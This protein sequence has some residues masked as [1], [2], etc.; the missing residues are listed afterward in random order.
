[1]DENSLILEIENNVKFLN[2]FELSRTYGDFGDWEQRF[3][4]ETA[5]ILNSDLTIKIRNLRNFR[6]LQIFVS[7]RP[8]VTL[9]NIYHSSKLYYSFKHFLNYFLGT[10]RGGVREAMDGFG[11]LEELGF[12]NILRSIPSS[13]IGNPLH[14]YRKGCV[15]TQRY[16]WN[17]YLIGVFRKFLNI[18]LNSNFIAMDIGCSYG[19][20]SSLLKKIYP[21]SH[22]ILVDMPGQLILAHYYL[23][24]LFPEA[25][26]AGFRDVGKVVMIDSE[27]VKKYDFILLP[28]SMYSK[29]STDTLDVVSNFASLS[30]MTRHWFDTYIQ[31]EPFKKAKFLFTVNRYDAYPTYQ[32][33]VTVLDYPFQDYKRIL[34]GTCPIFP[35]YYLKYLMFFY[36]RRPYPSQFFQFI[37][38]RMNV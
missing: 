16:I 34:M 18:K 10:Q 14:I 17:I 3:K 29:L 7:D 2:D 12:D 35:F 21:E 4:T 24:N 8:S 25:K 11:T 32:S 15:F 33:G 6:G 19:L 23:Q 37:G 36:E 38:E 5:K 13:G 9:K 26:I 31:S 20:F 27:F 28:V 30:E 22:H 1:M